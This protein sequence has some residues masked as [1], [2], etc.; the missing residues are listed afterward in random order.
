MSINLVKKYH[1]KL[2]KSLEYA[3]NLAGKTTDEYK[4]DGG[5]GIYL[6]SIDPIALSNYNKAATSNRYGTPTEV[7]DNQ[8]YIGWDY[9]KSYPATVDKANYQDGGYLK[10]A[11]AVIEEQN[12][13]VVA[14]FIEQNFYS[15]LCGNAGK[16]VTGNAPT[17]SDI[18]SRLTAIEAAFK[19]ARIPRLTGTSQCPPP[20][21]S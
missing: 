21:S 12:N 20:F 4:L 6:T 5:E 13:D 18:M 14:P 1:D 16:V 8:Q 17:A 9:D 19:N 3:S 11:G 10:T 7:Q 2:V 15:K